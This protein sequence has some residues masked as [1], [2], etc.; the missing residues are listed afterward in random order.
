MTIPAGTRLGPYEI[1]SPLGAG[2]MGEVYRARDTRLAREV[3]VKVLPANRARDPDALARMEREAQA[4]AA[5]S[6][7]NILAIHDLGTDQGVFF[8]VTELLEGE[9]LRSRLASSGLPWR[10]SV[11]IGAAIADGLA[12]AHLKGIVHRDLK[13]DNIFL[14]RD[15]RVKILDFGLARLQP[16]II[17]QDQTSAPTT[18]PQTEPGLLM[19]TVGYMSPE[20]ARGSSADTRSDIFA[21]GCVLYEML[22]GRRAF[23]RPTAPETLTAILNEDPPD[24]SESGKQVPAGLTRLLRR[25]LEKNP[26]E[27]LQAA[28]D[29]AFDLRSILSDSEI[30]KTSSSPRVEISPQAPA[31]HI[32]GVE[33]TAAARSPVRVGSSRRRRGLLFG[34]LA[35]LVSLLIAAALLVPRARERAR[36]Q[37]TLASLESAAAAG[38]LDEVS[39]LLQE[40]GL[41]LAE[42]R[43]AGLAQK[44]GGTLSV[45]S[46]PPGAAVTV[47]RAQP[48]SGFASRRPLTIGRAPA[49]ARLLAGEYLV[50]LTADGMNPVEFLEPIAVGKDSRAAR[51][52]V[53]TTAATEGM[54]LVD[55]GAS[56]ASREGSVVP[57][58]L[59]DKNEVT[60]TQFL[61]F[62]AAGGYRD[63][64]FWPETLIVNGKATPW[65]AAMPAFLDRT[66][67]PGPRSWSGGNFPEGK[68]DHPVVGVSWYEATAYGRWLGKE[69]PTREQWWRAALGDTRWAFPWGN[70]VK[71]AESRANFGLVGTRPIGSYPLGVSPFGCFDMAGNVREW[72]RE[73]AADSAMRSVVGGSWEDP[74]Y[75]F[76]A[77]HIETFEPAFSNNSIGFRLVRPVPGR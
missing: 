8:V 7:P 28:R 4:I 77:S 5:L 52:L 75:M 29:L 49:S 62:I 33:E 66:G 45:T 69:L 54:T 2:G 22:T 74:A 43:L 21:L 44:A 40:K 41:D 14:T 47:T 68:G 60:N 17:Q 25:C 71:T 72:L 63:Q 27:R 58:F 36:F 64:T 53:A 42:P 55:E 73:P 10:K 26:E 20:Q 65:K 3:A 35:L 6:H 24:V 56:S 30:E 59:I 9:T 18:P 46:E 16:V 48:V 67:L 31:D 57:A 37:A 13:P 50:R 51:K 34:A 76:E 38:H 23:S 12:G 61:R 39:G 15:G 32:R 11:E 70:D 19:G 1:L